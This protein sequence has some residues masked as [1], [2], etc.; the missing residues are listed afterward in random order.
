MAQNFLYMF[1]FVVD[2]LLVTRSNSCAPEEYPTC[3]EVSF[4]NSVFISICDREFGQCVDDCS[5]KCGKCCL[6]ALESPITDSDK[7]QIHVYKKKTEKCKFLVGCTEMPV[8]NLFDKVMEKFNTENPNW[9]EMQSKHLQNIPNSS[10]PKKPTEIIDNDCDSDFE[11][12]REQLCPTS[13]LT[14]SLLPLFNLKR[15][16]TGNVVLIIRLVANG[17]AIVSTFPLARI[18]EAGCERKLTN[19]KSKKSASNNKP[20]TRAQE[21]C[22][23]IPDCCSG[24]KDSNRNGKASTMRCGATKQYKSFQN[25]NNGCMP[26]QDP[27]LKEVKNP[28]CRRYFA[29]NADKGCPCDYVEDECER[30]KSIQI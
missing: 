11:G 14:K 1:E 28:V 19:C 8:K 29:C 20:C 24:F 30:C 17:P 27:C 4:R 5:P 6:F 7:L 26:M 10:E 18:C 13:E 15:S 3:C 9:Q 12:R 22:S 16:Q 23:S 21:I 2:D 25:Q